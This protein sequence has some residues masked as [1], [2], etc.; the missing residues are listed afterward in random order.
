VVL[1]ECSYLQRKNWDSVEYPEGVHNKFMVTA[2]NN[3]FVEGRKIVGVMQKDSKKSK[4]TGGW[5]FEG[6]K[7]ETKERVVSDTNNACFHCHES[8]K[9]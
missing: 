3:A 4:D 5:G 1:F 2:E 9:I 7:D 8:Q 6:F